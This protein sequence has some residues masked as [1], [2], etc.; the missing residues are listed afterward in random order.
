M[1]EMLRDYQKEVIMD[2]NKWFSEH[3]GNPCIEAPTA[4]GKSWIIAGYVHQALSYYPNTRIIIL[5]PQRELI[6][7]DREK[8]LKVWPKAPVSTFCA[9]LHQKEMGTQIVIAT[10]Q[11]IKFHPEFLIFHR[12]LGR[13]SP[14]VFLPI[15]NPLGNSVSDVLTVSAY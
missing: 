2:L 6:E 9:A 3:E 11:S 14:T 13:C 15:E 10:I 8:L 1:L 4:S 12:I 5:A 7:Q